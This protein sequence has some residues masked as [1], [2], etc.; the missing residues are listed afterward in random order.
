MPL[1][2]CSQVTAW[3]NGAHMKAERPGPYSK[4]EHDKWQEVKAKLGKEVAEPAMD[5]LREMGLHIPSLQQLKI[6][7]KKKPPAMGATQ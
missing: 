3:Q 2:V 4:N 6:K 5:Q 7:A 1:D